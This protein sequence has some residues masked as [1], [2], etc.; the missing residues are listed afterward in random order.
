MKSSVILIGM[1][2]AGKSTVGVLLAK[3]LAK[4]FVDTDILIQEALGETLQSYLDREGY[5]ALR[6]REEEM[7]VKACF[8]HH[9]IATGGSAVYSEAGMS[10]LTQVGV[11]V[12]LSISLDTVKQRVC[13][14]ATRGIASRAG[15]TLEDIYQERQ[16]LYEKY[17]QV[18]VVADGLTPELVAQEIMVK[19]QSIPTG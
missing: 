11:V 19:V 7:L 17:A 18:T 3:Y 12:Y 14:Q 13:N 8:D 16:S 9:V 15:S 4:A 5:I 2:G 10:A 1:P 6:Q